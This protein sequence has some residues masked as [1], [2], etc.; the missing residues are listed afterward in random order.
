MATDFLE[1]V[2]NLVNDYDTKIVADTMMRECIRPKLGF[3][4]KDDGNFASAED[5]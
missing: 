2:Q 5:E 1:Q 4:S 3:G